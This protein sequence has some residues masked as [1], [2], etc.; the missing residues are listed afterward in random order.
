MRRSVARAAVFPCAVS[1]AGAHA[2]L[3]AAAPL[4]LPSPPLSALPPAEPP[5]ALPSVV[6]GRLACA[7]SAS[8]ALDVDAGRLAGRDDA[9][10]ALAGA[11][12]LLRGW[13]AAGGAVIFCLPCA[14]L[15]GGFGAAGGGGGGSTGVLL[16]TGLFSARDSPGGGWFWDQLLGFFAG[17]SATLA[18]DF[19]AAVSST[20]SAF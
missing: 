5:S 7:S 1:G 18:F 11:G 4:L 8:A 6:R 2:A 13:A 3:D 14:F 10:A 12:E 9:A 20:S 16:R 15:L 19:F 17:G